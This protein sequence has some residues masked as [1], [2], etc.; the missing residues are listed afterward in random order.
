[1]DKGVSRGRI[2]N[3]EDVAQAETKGDGHDKAQGAV[4]R[5]RPHDGFGKR[6]RRISNLLRHVHGRVGAQQGV[7]GCQQADHERHAVG[8]P[9]AQVGDGAKDVRGGE[10]RGQ[11]PQRNED[12]EEADQVQNQHQA[13]DHGKFFGEEGVENDAESGNRDDQE[14]SVPA[15][16]VIVDIVEHDQ[17]LDDGADDEA[18]RG[19]ADL[20]AG[21]GNPAWGG[22]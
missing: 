2:D 11:N 20:P 5:G 4:D 18:E 16:K 10:P 21:D 14:R 15:L 8:G 9:P 6:E 22:S 17:A 19:Q 7:D 13:F 12:G 1:M 3:G